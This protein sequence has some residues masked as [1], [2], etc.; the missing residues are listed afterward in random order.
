MPSKT[1]VLV[2]DPNQFFTEVVHD[3]FEDRR[4]ATFPM[5]ERYMVELLSNFISASAFFNEDL[6]TG[7]RPNETLAEMLYQATQIESPRNHYILK[8]MGD[9]SLYVS[10]FFGDSLTRKV[11]D[12]EYYAG[13]GG[14]AYAALAGSHR[15]DFSRKVYK[16]YSHRF[17]DFVEV[18]TYISQK[19]MIQND[20]NLL[21]L[22]ERYVR[23]GDRLAR[24]HLLEK[25]I[26]P[27][28]DK[29]SLKQ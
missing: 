1:E 9:V 22:Y 4:I 28:D 29:K 10:G 12:V 20:Q 16:E 25:G 7:E 6:E 18:L 3:A 17:L 13:M 24:E 27:I 11:V 19:V 15:D 8:R 2:V 14:M 5:A 26:I 21:S 23:T